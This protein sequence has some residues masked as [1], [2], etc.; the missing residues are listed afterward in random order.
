MK[1][2]FNLIPGEGRCGIL[3]YGR[4]GD[5]QAVNSED[6]TRE[7]IDAESSYKEIDVRINSEGGDVYTGIAI[8]NALRQSKANITIYIDGIAASMASVIASCGKP[9]KMAKYSRMMIHSIQAGIYGNAEDLQGCIT[10]LKAM[11]ETLCS[12]YAERTGMAADRIRE[13][14]FDSKEHWLN[15]EEAL[16]LGFIDEIYD[17]PMVENSLSK[18]NDELFK[19]IR[20][21]S[22][23]SACHNRKDILS[24]IDKLEAENNKYRTIE[25]EQRDTEIN[26]L[27]D[28]SIKEG[29]IRP[30]QRDYIKSFLIN[31]F[32]NGKRFLLNQPKKRRVMDAISTGVPADRSLWTLSDYRKNNPQELKSNPKLYD[33]LLNEESERRA[34]ANNQ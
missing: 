11:E 16:S 6:V 5:G 29:R 18:G 23:F 8:F 3:L 13:E 31:D 33:R 9:V 4:I 30:A 10:E 27:I 22:Q 15:A 25:Q 1:K 32:E 28:D 17:M 26:N 24:V 21:R 34:K 14:Y 20:K 2:F 12:I 7:L 19:D